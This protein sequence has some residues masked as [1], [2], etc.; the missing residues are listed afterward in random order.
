MAFNLTVLSNLLGTAIEPDFTG[1]ELLIED[2]A[3]HEYRI[4]R[5]MFHVTGSP[6]SAAPPRSGW[7][8]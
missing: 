2:V 1:A 6:R 4:D 5:T 3:E 7:A 8:G